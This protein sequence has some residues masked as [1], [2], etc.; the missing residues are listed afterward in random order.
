ML[1]SHYQAV[2]LITESKE[3]QHVS[4]DA[5]AAKHITQPTSLTSLFTSLSAS[6]TSLWSASTAHA[7]T[8][9]SGY[10]ELRQT[11]GGP[12]GTVV[13]SGE[14]I[15][16]TFTWSSRDP[17]GNGDDGGIVIKAPNGWWIRQFT[18][19]RTHPIELD[20]FDLRH[21]EDITDV[22]E[23]IARAYSPHFFVRVPNRSMTLRMKYIDFDSY[24]IDYF[25]LLE[26]SSPVMIQ[27]SGG[28]TLFE[29]AGYRDFVLGSPHKKANRDNYN[30]TISGTYTSSDHGVGLGGQPPMIRIDQ[31]IRCGCDASIRVNTLDAWGGGILHIGRGTDTIYISGRHENSSLSVS[32]TRSVVFEDP[33][34][35]DPHATGMGWT[36]GSDGAAR[37]DRI[38]RI[39]ENSLNGI[40]RVDG[41]MTLQYG[42]AWIIAIDIARFGS[43]ADDPFVITTK[44]LG[45]TKNGIAVQ[46]EGS[47]ILN[48]VKFD[49]VDQ[50]DRTGNRF[51]K[52][53]EDN[54]F[55]NN[56]AHKLW[57]E[58]S[59]CDDVSSQFCHGAVSS[60]TTFI[61]E[62]TSGAVSGQVV[63]RHP[64]DRVHHN[65]YDGAG[66]VAM[67]RGG[68]LTV[69]DHDTVRNGQFHDIR[70]IVGRGNGTGG[71]NNTIENVALTGKVRVDEDVQ[72]TDLKNVSWIGNARTVMEIARGADVTAED[73]CAPSGSRISG[74]GVL[75]IDGRRVSL[76]YVFRTSGSCDTS[77]I[78]QPE[79]NDP[80]T[81]QQPDS[82][83]DSEP[84]QDPDIDPDESIGRLSVGDRV[85]VASRLRVRSSAGLSAGLVG[86]QA[87]NGRGVI[88]DGPVEADGYVWWRIDYDLGAT[89]WSAEEWLQNLEEW[90]ESRESDPAPV[91][92]KFESGDRIVVTSR[93][94]VRSAPTTRAALVGVQAP[95]GLGEIIG[96]PVADDGYVWWHIRYDRGAPGWSAEQWIE[97]EGDWKLP[98]T[99]PTARFTINTKEG[100]APLPVRFNASIAFDE[101]GSI[102]A[103]EWDFDD[104]TTGTGKQLTH[105]YAP[106]SYNPTL[107][108]RD[109]DGNESS[110]TGTTITVTKANEAPTVSVRADE[111]E[112]TAPAHISFSVDADDR[113]GRVVRTELYKDGRRI[114]ADTRAPYSFSVRGLDVGTHTYEVAAVDN[115]GARSTDRV[116]ITVKRKTQ[117]PYGAVP[118]ISGDSATRIEAERFDAGGAGLAYRD[119]TSGNASGGGFRQDE[120]VD[121]WGGGVGWIASG[122]WLEYTV[123][124]EP[125]V[126]EL[127]VR[128]SAPYSGRRV[129]L[130]VDGKDVSG[131]IE[132]VRTGSFNTYRVTSKSNVT[133]P[134][135][136]RVVRLVFDT[137]GHNI[138]WFEFRKVNRA[139]TA[140]FSRTPD[141]GVAPLS[142]SFDAGDSRDPDGSIASYRWDFG[143]GSHG[144][145]VRTTHTYDSAGSY[146]VT[147]SVTDSD[148]KTART[149]QNV[150]VSAPQVNTLDNGLMAL[151]ECESSADIG[152][153]SVGD[154]H[155]EVNRVSRVPGRRNFGNACDFSRT[156][157][158]LYAPRGSMF[159]FTGDDSF[160]LAG[161]FYFP[162]GA[163]AVDSD[164]NEAEIVGIS[165]NSNI[166]SGV[167]Y[168]LYARAAYPYCV[169][170][171]GTRLTRTPRANSQLKPGR[172]YFMACGYDGEAGTVFLQVDDSHY[173]ADHRGGIQDI[174]NI[175]AVAARGRATDTG[176]QGTV[177]RMDHL[178][179]WNRV[180]SGRELNALYDGQFRTADARSGISRLASVGALFAKMVTLLR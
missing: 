95:N 114:A 11:Y 87:E 28:R 139:P 23:H 60:H 176:G 64:D 173:T 36:G 46:K 134:S 55:G 131:P 177:M 128:A 70:L 51:I 98:T 49:G 165:G 179:I 50:S 101:D 140:A 124:I 92:D 83:S 149:G 129:H 153:D 40:Y 67:R 180:L 158:S 86:V 112:Y 76:P 10:G 132:L 15:G 31:S 104:G 12:G 100:E 151:Y 16:G 102:T 152:R 154:N 122:E 80:P 57:I 97:K 47:A 65:V 6:L 159:D 162:E 43:S 142:V 90:E 94:R 72:R 166:T 37:E 115:D 156:W 17:H 161:W 125:G 119:T 172:W 169:V 157:H 85:R 35:T 107:T 56:L 147:L 113:D 44:D 68:T 41:S 138:D 167:Q 48:A 103:Y 91:S 148:G 32:R 78:T 66:R 29:V 19:D 42:W 144:S 81:N 89:G 127:R 22:I 133:L 58:A 13:V 4:S 108:V 109:N 171:D 27:Q 146:R 52:I 126:Y 141:S 123:D 163:E 2:S 110:F 34:V 84:K 116:T 175:F 71:I 63:G 74:S 136:R 93:L 21:G 130:E 178:G 135:G 1:F 9:V 69:S 105:T 30:L 25:R 75:R 118:R 174:P 79:D 18:Y 82:E 111:D 3:A 73:I 53:V 170:S 164:N 121:A 59:V 155:L 145:G 168:A 99:P 24:D 117:R 61:L 39:R 33:I 38:S 106:G 96:G 8:T 26:S 7:Q 143:D 45:Y 137:G 77:F 88:V 160:T 54:T 20:W 120:D 150:S 62:N 14:H 5:S